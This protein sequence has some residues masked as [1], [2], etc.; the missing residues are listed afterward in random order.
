MATKKNPISLTKLPPEQ[1]RGNFHML[2]LANPNYFG[3]LKGSELDPVLLINGDTSFEE[4]GCVGFSD[5]LSRLEAVVS[6]KQDSGYGGGLCTSGSQEYVRFY[7]SFDG[8]TTWQDQGATAFNAHDIS[9]PKPLEYSVAQPISVAE[10]FCFFENLPQVRAILS[11]NFEPPANTPDFIPVWGNVVN[12]TI[13]I[14]AFEFIILSGLL[15]KAKVQLPASF[16]NAVNLQQ[17]IPAAP[18]KALSVAEIGTLYKGKPVTPARYLYPQIQT[19]SQNLTTV[20]PPVLGSSA[21]SAKKASFT[22]IDVNLSDVIAAILATSGDTTYEELDCVGLDINRDTLVGVVK[23]KLPYGFNGGLCTAGSTE[24]VAF[25]VDW[26]SGYEYEGTVSQN[27]HDIAG[28]P[29]G[30][31]EYAVVLP[32]DVASHQQPCTSGPQIVKVRAIL[33]WQT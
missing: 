1:A 30:G 4:I 7:L 19:L 16:K 23:V 13:Q 11:W 28:V 21:K 6:I 5:S 26:G 33:S 15:D 8:G 3:N 9:G 29:A 27:V 25:W 17:Q 18:K 24:Y 22:P 32:V 2:L 14:P 10:D 31:L 20:A 12:V